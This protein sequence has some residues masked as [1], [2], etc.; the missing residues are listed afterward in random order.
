MGYTEKDQAINLY[1]EGKSR[2]EISNIMG[3]PL[4][5]V[6]SWT[7]GVV[8]NAYTRITIL[9]VSLREFIPTRWGEIKTTR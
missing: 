8:S 7:K 4:R 9:S 1:L 3:K 2:R 5:T 6:Q